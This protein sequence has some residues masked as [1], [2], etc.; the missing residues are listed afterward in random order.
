MPA[1]PGMFSVQ[2]FD[3]QAPSPGA[4]GQAPEAKSDGA[5]RTA[6]DRIAL[7]NARKKEQGAASAPAPAAA[8]AAAAINA[9]ANLTGAAALPASFIHPS[10]L[11][12][13]QALRQSDKKT[14]SSL[15][16][17]AVEKTKAKQRY[18]NK[19]K[20]RRKNREKTQ[21]IKQKA[22]TKKHAQQQQQQQQLKQPADLQAQRQ[23]GLV[24][25]KKSDSSSDSSQSSDS[26]DSE[27]DER[28][29]AAPRKRR[30]AS[31]SP[32]P[33]TQ[34]HASPS[35]EAVPDLASASS[36]AP[37]S[38]SSASSLSEPET[39]ADEGA[40]Q[41]PADKVAEAE[42]T[43]LAAE[44]AAD[45]AAVS[46]SQAGTADALE[47]FPAPRA[48]LQASRK[49]LAAQGL[50]EGLAK[51]KHIQPSMTASVQRSDTRALD[52]ISAPMKARLEKLGIHEWFA[53]QTAIIPMLLSKPQSYSLYPAQPLGDVCVSAPTGSGK[54]LSYAVPIVEILS[55]RVHRRLR[56]L[57][58]VPTRDLV[59]QV[60][61]S[62]AAIAKG[63]GLTFA[64]L[65]GQQSFAHEQSQLMDMRNA[66]VRR[67]TPGLKPM[68]PGSEE[69]G[70]F[71]ALQQAMMGI[72]SE[73]RMNQVPASNV[74]VVIATPGRLI[75]HLDQTP[76]FTMQHLRFLVIDEADRLLS[77]SF[78]EWLPRLLAALDPKQALKPHGSS[79]ECAPERGTNC[80][81]APA[82]IRQQHLE[83][84]LVPSSIVPPLEGGVQKLL[85]SATLTRDPARIVA[86]GL[87][88]AAFVSVE[89]DEKDENVKRA[90]KEEDGLTGK[91]DNVEPNEE[92]ARD[93]PR[94][95]QDSF[96]LPSSLHEHMVVTSSADKPLQLLHLLYSRDPSL[97]QVLCFTKSL[98]SAARL[99][100]LIDLF[101][102][103]RSRSTA[104]KN[105]R[106]SSSNSGKDPRRL[107]A[108]EYSSE[109]AAGERTRLLDAFKGG[110]IDVLVC[111]DIMARGID[112]PS[113]RHV[114][115][116]DMPTHM[117]NYVHRVGRTARA[118]RDG[119]A[120]TL[121]ETHEARHFTQM[122][123]RAQRWPRISKEKWLRPRPSAPAPHNGSADVEMSSP[124]QAN[125]T[126]PQG[127]QRTA[128]TQ[129]SAAPLYDDDL[130]AHYAAA[131]KRL[132]KLYARKRR[133]A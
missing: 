71:I 67:T 114:V 22:G 61:E 79:G 80:P 133:A 30:R 4:P 44:A 15:Q 39:E 95:W 88:D 29:A 68:A 19:K 64:T 41:H 84:G 50:P 45:A 100:R 96:A 16:G 94:D 74:D 69:E 28:T 51:P 38:S 57:I 119:D 1:R 127:Q 63:T 60:R 70:E 37:S 112:L 26:N 76:G 126:S 65:T 49:D 109:Q 131:L 125:E 106:H 9:N 91:A 113:V 24:H 98:E 116:Y 43:A 83:R 14:R 20:E 6:V 120:W 42:Q 3:G 121:V 115:S 13:S 92:G 129:A 40:A 35:K 90:R 118:G 99:V 73:A 21:K 75:D 102:E 23:Y 122:M 46:S 104:A 25:A 62:F 111:S 89:G 7:L 10:R 34:K 101:Q 132:E 85:F 5:P 2:R 48:T 47:R 11:A 58:L 56:A 86:L 77:Q 124:V 8:T 93:D 87:R 52:M 81:L 32:T 66:P 105:S 103:E 108:R 53:V 27:D 31:S 110:D 55:K 18:L 54:T 117:A 130:A 33:I 97:R 72:D 123:R 12:Q 59:H 82:W 107:V 78:Q 128:R 36:S 17:G